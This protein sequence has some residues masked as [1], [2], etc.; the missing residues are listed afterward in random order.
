[1]PGKPAAACSDV[2]RYRPIATQVAD[3]L[4]DKVERC[5]SG[6]LRQDVRLGHAVLHRQV[7]VQ[8]RLTGVRRPGRRGRQQRPLTP[9]EL[10]RF[11]ERFQRRQF[12]NDRGIQLLRVAGRKTAW[13]HHVDRAEDSG[14]LHRDAGGA[15]AAHG[16][17]DE[18]A[19]LAIGNRAVVTVDVWDYFCGELVRKIYKFAC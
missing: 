8:R 17:S 12:S 4:V 11:V 1:M 18:A 2:D 19:A 5:I 14:M 15:V 9:C 7:K 10:G 13:A 6:P 3:I 16:M